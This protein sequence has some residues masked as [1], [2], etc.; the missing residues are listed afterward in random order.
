MASYHVSIKEAASVL[1]EKDCV[2]GKV[3]S[4]GQDR[5]EGF[6]NHLLKS[7]PKPFIIIGGPVPNRVLSNYT[8]SAFDSDSKGRCGA[9]SFPGVC[10]I[11][12]RISQAPS[13]LLYA[14]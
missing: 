6:V 11:R 12:V 13:Y 3:T 9:R 1:N 2:Q 14:Y 10:T 8:M 4:G 7:C 5:H